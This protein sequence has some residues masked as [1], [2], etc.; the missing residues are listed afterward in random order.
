MSNEKTN[1]SWG[2]RFSE[3]VDAFV[4]RF[5]ASVDFD[6]RLYRHD[7]MGSIAHATML[8]KVGVLTNDERD[9]VIAGLQAIEKEIEAGQFV[10]ST[11]LEDVHMN[12]EAR[13]TEQVGIVGKK[14]HTGRSRNDQVA[15]DIRLWLRDEIDLILAELSRLQEGL[16]GLA[17]EHAET[18]MPGFTHLQTAQPVTFGHHMLAWF[19]M[20]SRDYERLVDC[21]KRT[22]RMPLGSAALAG[23]TYPIDRQM[24]CE[25]L[26]FEAI[27]GNSLDG[28]SDRDFAIEF[29]AAA[30]IAMM[31]LSRF[32]EE[33]VLWT[34]AQF[35][36]VDLPDRF[37]TGSSIMPQKKNPDVPELVRGKSG[38]VF[39]AL[40]GLLTLMKGQPLA[41]NKDNQ[42]DKE[43][44]FDAAD[45]LRD[46]LRAFADMVPAIVP[47]QEMM[48][49]AAL[50]GFSTA[51]D[52][53]DY[54]VGKGLPFR[55]CHEI[56]GHAVGYGVKE[57][58]D[59][60]QMSLAE[61]QQFS[62][63]ISEDVFAVLTLEGSVNARNHIG[64]TAP[65]Q[66]R[67]A[68]QRGRELLASR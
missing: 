43:P 40:M 20:L 46:S 31:H 48:R 9:T 58:K 59:L 37:C 53:A 36:F 21:R 5:T 33:L 38:R 61:L 60:A 4:A 29:C 1:Q 17:Q 63:E 35:Q 32:S 11:E 23:T 24:T 41:Y 42:E 64:G 50:R 47:K 22:N 18:I 7:I 26:G 39:G 25:L 51:T 27:S 13:L 45:T 56:V 28:V 14:L 30:S 67:A 49:E 16:L 65:A 10:W 55:D 57:G 44:L 34:S 68:V 62:S 66:V 52:L 19:E 15:T 12:I 6:Q 3:P 54:L 8:A 2:G